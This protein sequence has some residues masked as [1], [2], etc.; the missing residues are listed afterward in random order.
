[1]EACQP[2]TL[3]MPSASR[4]L[5]ARRTHLTD[6]D[7]RP[8]GRSGFNRASRARLEVFR[9]VFDRGPRIGDPACIW[10]GSGGSVSV[11][12]DARMVLAWYAGPGSRPSR[13]PERYV[14]QVR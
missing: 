5:G 11:E 12:R 6:D 3:K 13:P 9:A 10:Q 4:T 1:M 7:A 2:S 8:G 14:A